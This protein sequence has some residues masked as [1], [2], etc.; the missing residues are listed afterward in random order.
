MVEPE[1]GQAP[2][3]LMDSLWETAVGQPVTLQEIAGAL[4]RTQ[5]VGSLQELLVVGS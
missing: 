5:L 1:C 4:L 3:S 2:A